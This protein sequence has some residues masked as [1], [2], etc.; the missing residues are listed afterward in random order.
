MRVPLAVACAVLLTACAPVLQRPIG[1]TA[2]VDAARFQLEG[3]LS[4]RQGETR[5]H[6]GISWRHAG[7][8]DEILLTGPLGQGVAELTRDAGGARLTTSDRQSLAAADWE[9]LAERAF[10]ARLPLSEMPRWVVGAAPAPSVDGWRI[11][12]LE[13][14]SGLPV[15]MELRRG[16]I[17]LRLKVDAW[18]LP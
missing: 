10:G 14:E 13:Y 12:Y 2:P 8:S 11:D 9:S 3:R 17:E 7:N 16:D 6:V 18:S 4:V 5:H 15:L 1:P